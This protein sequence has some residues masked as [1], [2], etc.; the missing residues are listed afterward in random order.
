MPR[1]LAGA[2]LAWRRLALE[3]WGMPAT[4]LLQKVDAVTIPVPSLEAGLRFYRDAS[5]TSCGGATTT[6]ARPAWPWPTATRRSS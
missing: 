2:G 4:A 5:G 3:T 6:P 1:H